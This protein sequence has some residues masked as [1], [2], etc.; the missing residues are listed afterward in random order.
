MDPEQKTRLVRELSSR[1]NFYASHYSEPNR[2]WFVKKVID[3]FWPEFKVVDGLTFFA[4]AAPTKIHVPKDWTK[5]YIEASYNHTHVLDCFSHKASLD[6]EPYWNSSHADFSTACFF[7]KKW[8][9]AVLTKL[10][11]DFP[12]QHFRVYFI[13]QD[14]PIVRFHQIRLNELNW[15]EPED[16]PE[17][18]QSG[19]I[20][21]FDSRSMS[22]LG[23]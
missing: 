4:F 21:I 18:I 9:L 13:T 20:L 10:R 11:M 6:E 22:N 23:C 16:N 19:E 5:S 1:S 14:N 12:N 3:Y 17:G 15:L 8:A 7:G 2:R